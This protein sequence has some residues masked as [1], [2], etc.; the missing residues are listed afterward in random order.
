MLRALAGGHQSQE[1]VSA[2]TSKGERIKGVCSP[3]QLRPSLATPHCRAGTPAINAALDEGAVKIMSSFTNRYS[4]Q[5]LLFK[6]KSTPARNASLAAVSASFSHPLIAPK[7]VTTGPGT[8]SASQDFCQRENALHSERQVAEAQLDKSLRRGYK[9]RSGQENGRL[10]AE[11]HG[12]R[13]LLGE[14][15]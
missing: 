10:A 11:E 2:E 4:R 5:R 13:L 8:P 7:S 6:S 1:L 12:E 14:L 3:L 15:T 9:T